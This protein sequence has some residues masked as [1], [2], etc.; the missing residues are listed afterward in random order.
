M[1]ILYEENALPAI[2]VLSAKDATNTTRSLTLKSMVFASK[3]IDTQLVN[4]LTERRQFVDSTLVKYEGT[5]IDDK[6]K[7]ILATIR[8]MSAKVRPVMDEV[9]AFGRDGKREAGFKRFMQP[10]GDAAFS[11][12]LTTFDE[13]AQYLVEKSG[14][15]KQEEL[16]AARNA[17]NS[18]IVTS[19]VILAIGISFGL[20]VSRVITKPLNNL[21]GAVAN[22]ASGDLSARLDTEGRDEVAQMGHALFDM[23][24]TLMR[25]ISTVRDASNSISETAHDFSAMAQQTNA[26]VEEF[27][28]SAD[29][30]GHNLDNLASSSEEIN[31]SVEE[32]AAGA[33]ATAERGTDI[34]RKVDE[35]MNAGEAGMV[36][37]QK[38]TTSID[39]VARKSHEATKAVQELG[40]NARQI[41]NFVTQIGGI[42]DQTNLLALNAAIEAARAGDA[43][44]GFAV[45]AEEVRKLA[46]DSNVAA[47]SIAELASSI[48]RDL[49]KVVTSAIENAKESEDAKGLAIETDATI[50]DM[51]SYLRDIASFTQ[52]LAA[53][54]QEQAASS[55]EIAESVQNMAS[56]V[57][58]SAE[59]ALRI[60]NNVK[61]VAAAS[62]RVA[63]GADNLTKLSGELQEELSFFKIDIA[64]KTGGGKG[65]KDRLAL[66]P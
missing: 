16:I 62:E 32:V 50:K 35:A 65:K 66:H 54:S 8:S 9:I 46:E 61:D 47:N 56:R 43:G 1:N 7:A 57:A 41:Q 28:S 17:R 38:A 15:I 36:A 60:S 33:Q 4:R 22:F 58:N 24:Q 44:R 27:K 5:N 31:A 12:L 18:M 55:G 13:L 64:S 29:E 30:M 59:G 20:F 48:T 11:L 14:R 6:E 21:R 42:A 63:M 2:Y 3:D 25:V 26:S 19:I 39:G 34:A 49:D 51:I 40:N 37:V 52:D 10:D 53:V 23:S 45:V